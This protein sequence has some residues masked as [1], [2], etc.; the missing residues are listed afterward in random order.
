[1]AQLEAII[2]D[3]LIDLILRS[4]GALRRTGMSSGLYARRTCF[5]SPPGIVGS[6]GETDVVELRERRRD[7][8]FCAASG[9]LT[10]TFDPVVTLRAEQDEV[11]ENRQAEQE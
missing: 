7:L 9:A 6:A 10:R 1:M 5:R 11:N 3:C 8:H 2:I 4:P